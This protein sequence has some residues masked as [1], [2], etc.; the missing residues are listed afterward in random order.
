MKPQERLQLIRNAAHKV[1]DTPAVET[2][3]VQ[4]RPQ[5]RSHRHPRCMPPIVLKRSEPMHHSKALPGWAF[6]PQS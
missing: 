1:Q 6:W 2:Q 4:R 3:D 5:T